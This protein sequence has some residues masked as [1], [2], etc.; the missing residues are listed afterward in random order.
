MTRLRQK[1]KKLKRKYERTMLQ[2]PNVVVLHQ[3]D[4]RYVNVFRVSKTI[5]KRIADDTFIGITDEYAARELGEQMLRCGYIDR[6]VIDPVRRDI[7]VGD[8]RW[9]TH[10][11]DLILEYSVT[12]VAPP[13][14]F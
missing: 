5:S 1:Y 9:L 10:D 11:D 12:V 6:E 2:S 4:R 3:S 14:R 7:T 13:G 8:V